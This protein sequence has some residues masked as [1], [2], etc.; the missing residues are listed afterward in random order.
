MFKIA[1]ARKQQSVCVQVVDIY[2]P[3][4]E[5]RISHILVSMHKGHS[6]DSDSELC[7]AETSA[8]SSLLI[9]KVLCDCSNLNRRHIWVQALH[10][11]SRD[12]IA[13]DQSAEDA[14][15]AAVA[16]DILHIHILIVVIHDAAAE[17]WLSDLEWL[18]L[19]FQCGR[20]AVQIF[21]SWERRCI[22]GTSILGSLILLVS[23]TIVHVRRLLA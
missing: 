20:H 12:V 9:I 11:A 18:T 23:G 21:I 22:V 19:R 2:V 6:T 14:V 15:T 7:K 10:S 1:K 16:L 13:I 17:T 5:Q 8:N 4:C 3:A